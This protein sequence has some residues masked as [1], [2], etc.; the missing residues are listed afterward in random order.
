MEQPT[1]I[2]FTILVQKIIAHP[3]RILDEVGDTYRG[4]PVVRDP[5]LPKNE[6]HLISGHRRVVMKFNLD[7]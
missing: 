1:T 2:D 4:I 7:T 6:I 5:T 3:D